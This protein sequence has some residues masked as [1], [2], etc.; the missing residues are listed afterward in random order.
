[1]PR[2]G[3]GEIKG[4]RTPI[5]ADICAVITKCYQLSHLNTKNLFLKLCKLE[6]WDYEPMGLGS[7]MGFLPSLQIVPFHTILNWT[8]KQG[9]SVEPLHK[10]IDPIHKA[11]LL[12]YL[13]L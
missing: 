8:R 11:L 1:M 10:D 7:G 13:K 3:R 5:L 2:L 6:V 4:W 9:S 12:Y